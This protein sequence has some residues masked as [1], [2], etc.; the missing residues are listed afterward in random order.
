MAIDKI[1]AEGINLSDTFAFTG[2]VSGVDGKFESQLLH[3]R[4][5]KSS[6]TNGGAS[7]AGSIWQTR[8]L[9]TIKKGIRNEQCSIRTRS[10]DPN[11]SRR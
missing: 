2:T 4:D 11:I 8:T 5:E 10:N 6:G 3:I 1:Q 7:S 9:N